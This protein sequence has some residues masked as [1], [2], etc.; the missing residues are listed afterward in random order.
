MAGLDWDEFERLLAVDLIN[1]PARYT[2]LLGDKPHLVT[3]SQLVDHL[4]L[5][6]IGPSWLTGE[7][8]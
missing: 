3:I 8:G 6:T 5:E 4:A 2:V 7:N 1:L